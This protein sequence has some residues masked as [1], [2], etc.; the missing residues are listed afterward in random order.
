MVPAV[1]NG[2]RNEDPNPEGLFAGQKFWFSSTVPQRSRFI[3]DVKANGGEVVPLEKQADICL[4][5]HARKNPPPGMY[6]YRYVEH[7]VRKGQLEDL[8][9]HRIAGVNTRSDRSVGSVTLASKGTRTAFTEADDQMLWEWVKPHEGVRGAAGNLIYQQLEATN[10]RHTYQSWR[11][12]WL[13]YVQFQERD[14]I[15]ANGQ[16]QHEAAPQQAN[17]TVRTATPREPLTRIDGPSGSPRIVVEVPLREPAKRG[18]A[19]PRMNQLGELD[20]DTI[21]VIS[22]RVSKRLQTPAMSLPKNN[23]GTLRGGMPSISTPENNTRSQKFSDEDRALLLNAAEA[24]LEADDDEG[25]PA[26][27]QMAAE[28]QSHTAEQWRKYFYEVIVP[29]HQNQQK[30]SS[31][32]I[33]MKIVKAESRDQDERTNSV[34]EQSE[35][36]QEDGDLGKSSA[37][38][39][40]NGVHINQPTAADTESRQSSPSFEPQSPVGW[41]SDND[42]PRSA[43]DQLRKR[44][45]A[46]SDSQGSVRPHSQNSRAEETQTL[47]CRSEVEQHNDE[48]NRIGYSPPAKRRKLSLNDP[49]V[50]EIPST[51]QPNQ[52]SETP[53]ELADTP[54]PRA[55]KRPSHELE[56]SSSPLFVPSDSED[57]ASSLPTTPKQ[58]PAS[59]LPETH[60]SPISVHLVSDRDPGIPSNSESSNR[61][62]ESRCTSSLTPDF[63]TA[64]DFPP[65]Q[66]D[67]PEEQGEASD[68]FDT[69]AE[70]QQQQQQPQRQRPASRAPILDTQALLAAPIQEFEEGSFDLDLAEPEGGWDAIEEDD[71]TTSNDDDDDA[72]LQLSLPPPPRTPSPT[73]STSTA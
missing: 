31:K 38:T 54:T 8:E 56:S 21:H 71:G 24:I 11:D 16:S 22:P 66:P 27:E 45:P 20:N 34:G 32:R 9:A 15:R 62:V 26:W 53:E 63:E 55:R 44:S 36:E 51:P 48:H 69:A 12:R 37:T 29:Y 43:S 13:K 23:A 17:P 4:Y 57:K 59:M 42:V 35:E 41:K 25:C 47:S 14:H 2:V 3:D 33:N 1:Y 73:P 46:K 72:Q 10:P 28:Q 39:G 50:L 6:S 70:E 60:T 40:Q 58:A 68:E 49:T 30:R 67:N 19:Q 18:R 52:E 5:D 65:I 61:S 7:S 64:P